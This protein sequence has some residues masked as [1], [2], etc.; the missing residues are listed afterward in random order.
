MSSY[1]DSSDSQVASWL[2]KLFGIMKHA[3]STEDVLAEECENFPVGLSEAVY[4]RDR[5]PVRQNI[6]NLTPKSKL[7]QVIRNVFV[8]SGETTGEKYILL[9]DSTLSGVDSLLL[10]RVN[11]YEEEDTISPPDGLWGM[12]AGVVPTTMNASC[13]RGKV[14]YVISALQL[15]S[16][17]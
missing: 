4:I 8:E 10:L 5:F 11:A 1:K 14:Y 3:E 6:W 9:V 2:G 12:R 13:L 15:A 7:I 16:M 17:K